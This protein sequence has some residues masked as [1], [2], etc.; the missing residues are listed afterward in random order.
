[1][2][3]LWD[4]LYPRRC[5]AC[6]RRGEWLCADCLL[7]CTVH[8]E[9]CCHRCGSR[10]R[11]SGCATC[12]RY[13]RNL[14]ELHAAYEYSGPVRELV[15]R[16][17]YNNISGAAEWIASRMPVDWLA[18][19]AVLVPVPLHPARRRRRG[20]NQAELVAQALARRLGLP[21]CDCLVRRGSAAAQVGRAR[22][23]RL[24]S[25]P[26]V[27]T[28]ARGRSAPVRAVLVD[29]VLTTGATIS[30]CARALRAAGSPEVA[31]VTYARTPGR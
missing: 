10:L 14:D 3:L 16:F 17:K 15:H 11:G 27:I 8:G 30:A 29:D 24:A 28:L 4:L 26:G 23:A 6:R 7:R 25:P 2:R 18:G 20:Y 1:M 21:L 12:A 19:G 31:A 9:G 5:A 13:I 22:G